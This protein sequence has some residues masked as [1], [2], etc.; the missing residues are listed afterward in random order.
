YRPRRPSE[1]GGPGER[2]PGYGRGRSGDARRDDRGGAGERPYRP[3]RASDGGGSGDRPGGFRRESG[4]GPRGGRTAYGRTG[5]SQ[6]AWE[7]EG[8][9]AAERRPAGP[10]RRPAGETG[11]ADR[12]RTG[13]RAGSPQR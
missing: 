2:A 11:R 3:R 4:T 6:R 7:D 13:S 5:G 1:G 12:G 9:G 10:R 8:T